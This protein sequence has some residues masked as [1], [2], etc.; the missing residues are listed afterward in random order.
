MIVCMRPRKQRAQGRGRAEGELSTLAVEVGMGLGGAA[1]AMEC[2]GGGRG[3]CGWRGDAAARTVLPEPFLPTMLRTCRGRY[4]HRVTEAM[5]GWCRARKWSEGVQC[6]W[7]E[8]VDDLWLV[9]R[10]A[11]N[12]ARQESARRSRAET[13][14]RQCECM[15]ASRGVIGWSGRAPNTGRDADAPADGQLVDARHAC[16]RA[17]PPCGSAKR[18]QRAPSDAR[19]FAMA[20]LRQACSRSR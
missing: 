1:V 17:A 11:P 4:K 6:E 15:V 3:M 8:K 14:A 19:S 16:C 2:V 12:A 9:G 7:F 13:H 20:R 5:T 10:E 18:G